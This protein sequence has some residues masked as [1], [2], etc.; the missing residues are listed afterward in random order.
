MKKLFTLL[1]LAGS[2]GAMA[3]PVSPET[4]LERITRH[5]KVRAMENTS[6]LQLADI[7]EAEGRNAVYLFTN[8]DGFVVTSADDAAPAVLGYGYGTLADENG[9]LPDNFSYFMDF[10]AKRVAMA[11]D[12]KG[13]VRIQR[14]SRKAIA[15]LCKT[16]WNQGSPYYDKCPTLYNKRGVTGCVATSMA[17]LLKYHEYPAKGKGSKTYYWEK[18][19]KN[20]TFDY[21]ATPFDWSNMLDTY[22]SNSSD[23]AVSRT[24]VA[25]LM[26]ACGVAV[27][28]MYSYDASGAYTP[29]I[30][31]ALVEIFDY[32]DAVRFVHRDTYSL[33]DWEEMMYNSL[34]NYGPICYG[35]QAEAGGHSFICDGYDKDGLFHIN[36]GWG[37]TS[38]GY[39]M[40]D[41]LDP[42]N[43]GI[44]GTDMDFNS[45]QDAVINAIPNP[46]GPK[47]A[48]KEY[49]MIGSGTWSISSSYL[50]KN[51]KKGTGSF[52]AVME[53]Y[54][55]GPWTIP[56][57]FN[58]S[59]VF[60][61]LENP[62][63]VCSNIDI[64]DDLG[65]FYGW[66]QNIFS[67]TIPAGLGK[68]RHA[69]YMAINTAEAG[70]NKIHWAY[71]A[72]PYYLVDCDGADARISRVQILTP[73]VN[74]ITYPAEIMLGD[75]V[76]VTANLFS[77]DANPFEGE[78]RL[79]LMKDNE[80]V[81]YGDVNKLTIAALSSGTLNYTSEGL[82]QFTTTRAED[83]QLP[84]GDY[85]VVL[86]VR[87][88]T[89]DLWIPLTYAAKVKID[90]P[91]GISAMEAD[92]DMPVEWFDLQ[93]RRID[94]DALTPGIYIRRQG[95][96]TEKAVIR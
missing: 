66:K 67:Y 89:N 26:S 93:G 13:N 1:L 14:P 88:G 35:G 8:A 63:T 27:E 96:K 80:V 47:D 38:D 56:A 19:R 42:Q 5:K 17:Q 4:A 9:Q 90:T 16:K 36:W 52:N 28:M 58:V 43:Q 22:K 61:S 45:G 74:D 59:A 72:S 7:R 70:I 25:T 51:L 68:G 2:M 79:E 83:G 65:I 55:Y 81:A 77:N 94:A 44:G 60:E 34:A 87:N 85:E 30:A 21:E 53:M 71:G 62:D 50:N 86:S 69:L 40:L 23:P 75:K 91:T 11:A 41:I 20:L 48:K 37:G 95:S 15:P 49:N 32:S 31:K 6:T 3:A 84:K 29:N 57:G 12:G 76:S 46:K 78:Y 54:N 82:K 24:A 39:F 64:D 18:G 10:L 92:D 73:R 33:Y